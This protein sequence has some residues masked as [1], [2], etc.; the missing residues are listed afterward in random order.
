MRTILYGTAEKPVDGCVA[1]RLLIPVYF[2]ILVAVIVNG[3][4]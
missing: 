1:M 2:S 4:L 3:N